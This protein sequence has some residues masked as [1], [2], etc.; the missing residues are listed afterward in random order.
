MCQTYTWNL[1]MVLF[2]NNLIINVHLNVYG[3][4]DLFVA[5]ELNGYIRL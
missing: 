3:F 1:E 5:E 2:F 4:S